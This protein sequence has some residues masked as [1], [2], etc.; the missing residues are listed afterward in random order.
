MFLAGFEPFIMVLGIVILEVKFNGAL[1]YYL[2]WGEDLAVWTWN[3]MVRLDHCV[4]WMLVA[5]GPC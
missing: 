1:E 5:T 2:A 3:L 4:G